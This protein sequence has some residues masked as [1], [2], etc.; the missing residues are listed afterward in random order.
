M[1]AKPLPEKCRSLLLRLG[2]RSPWFLPAAARVTIVES[3]D[4]E[5]ACVSLDGIVKVS[6]KFAAEISEAELTGV[7]AHELSHLMLYHHNRV[8]SRE[9]DRWNRATDRAINETLRQGGISLPKWALYP[10]TGKESLSAEELYEIEKVEPSDGGGEDKP[11][12]G[13][14]CGVER[15]G[16]NL[17]EVEG[18]A[19]DPTTKKGGTRVSLGDDGK[20]HERQW[21]E[22]AAQA[23]SLSRGTYAG[24]AFAKLLE[25]PKC[26]VR[27]D[28]ILRRQFSAA[29]AKH[30]NDDQAWHRRG[31][32]SPVD[33]P[34]VPGTIAY[35][36]TAAVVIDTSG[37]VSDE[38]LNHAVANTIAIGKSL[39][40]KVYLV[41][42]DS[43]VQWRGWLHQMT[44]GKIAP[45][46]SGRGGTDCRGAYRAVGDVKAR[47]DT[48]VHLTDGD[49]MSPDKPRNVGR[50]VIGLVGCKV[51]SMVPKYATAID[52][53]VL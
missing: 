18:E 14:G 12:A 16:C 9:H 48:M 29:V 32:R 10:P 3:S 49:I 35:K 31:R 26:R 36:A 17:G 4:I 46:L 38:A 23:K 21:R 2:W 50:V 25:P 45:A 30:G 28:Q 43:E 1:T 34:Q 33:G 19:G 11:M 53:E 44:P 42:H 52:A 15:P 22:T 51:R 40:V 13:G 27:W 37:S 8:G 39:G 7:L 24:S 41:T 5:T 6:P 20:Q 47:F